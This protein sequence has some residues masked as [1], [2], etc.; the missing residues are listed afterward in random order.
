MFVEYMMIFQS[1]ESFKFE[2]MESPTQ[3]ALGLAGL[4]FSSNLSFDS[5]N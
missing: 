2:N 1:K 5:S 4:C 3:K